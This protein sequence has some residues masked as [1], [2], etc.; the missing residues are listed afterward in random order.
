MAERSGADFGSRLRTAR[1]RRGVDLREISSRTKIP[2]GVLEA[3]ERNDIS[4]LPRG[5]FGRAFVRSYAAEIG[6]DPEQAVRDFVAA[7]PEDSALAGHAASGQI[8]D[9]E[10]VESDRQLAT[11]VLRLIL[12]SVPLAGVVLYFGTVGRRAATV[13]VERP[14]A[15]QPPASVPARVAQPPVTP[16]AS[17]VPDAVPTVPSVPDATPVAAPGDR[18]VVGLSVKRA[19]WISA[20]VDGQKAIDGLLQPGDARTLD[21]GHELVLT[22]GDGSAVVLTLNGAAARPIGRTG[23]VATARITPSNAGSFVGAR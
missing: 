2:I 13:P 16:A 15:V 17:T 20:T 6:L 12:V 14:A 19:C 8:E 4:R 11:T 7:F 10:A 21:V 3:L 1:E 9:N 22:A 23:D 18:L 5:I